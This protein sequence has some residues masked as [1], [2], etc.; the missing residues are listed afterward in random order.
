MWMFYVDILCYA[1]RKW[2]FLWKAPHGETGTLQQPQLPSSALP[3]WLNIS[4]IRKS[5]KQTKHAHNSQHTTSEY[6]TW[7]TLYIYRVKH[8]WH[9][10][11]DRHVT[12]P[13]THKQ[14]VWDTHIFWVK[15]EFGSLRVYNKCVLLQ[16]WANWVVLWGLWI[17]EFVILCL[18]ELT[19]KHILTN[20]GLF[21]FKTA[22]IT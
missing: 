1:F 3:Y 12:C 22:A 11:S 18:L 5:E 8:P 13:V 7:G 6:I 17:T 4:V 2:S 9:A 20:K 21:S 14:R 15:R 16:Y 19:I 10:R